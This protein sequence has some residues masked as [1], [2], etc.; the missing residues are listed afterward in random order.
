MM[1]RPPSAIR[2]IFSDA[3]R[4]RLALEA[5]R[6]GDWSWDAATDIV[7]LSPRAAEILGIASGRVMTWTAMRDIL[8]PDDRERERV[9]VETALAS[10]SDYDIEYRIQTN[11]GE[12][13]V[14]AR[15]H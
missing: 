7:T 4:L 3:E 13:W 14:V 2:S 1:D 9:A 15:G 10:R 6:L 11:V 8:H 12:T 5:A